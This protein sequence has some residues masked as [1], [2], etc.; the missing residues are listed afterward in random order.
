MKQ[1]DAE[2]ALAHARLALSRDAQ[3]PLAPVVMALAYRDLGNKKA[4]QDVLDRVMAEDRMNNL[5]F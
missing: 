5:V 4:A 3:H 2:T 1:G